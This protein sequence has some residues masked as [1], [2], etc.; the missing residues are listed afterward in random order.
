MNLEASCPK[1]FSITSGKGGTGKSFVAKNL[2]LAFAKLDKKV[3]A[4]DLDIGMRTLDLLFHL[5]DNIVFDLNDVMT[6]KCSIK[7]ALYHHEKYRNLSLLCG[8]A[9][10]EKDFS[11]SKMFDE[12][13]SLIKKGKY[14]IVI[15][16]LPS[17][18]GFNVLATQQLFAE[19][20]I[21]TNPTKACVRGDSILA[22]SL[23]E[24]NSQNGLYGLL[25]INKIDK[26][27]FSA[28]SKD[29]FANLDE[30]IDSIGLKLLGTLPNT[31]DA[32]FGKYFGAIAKRLLGNDVPL[33]LKV[34]K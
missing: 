14:D 20:I 7:D 27:A 18:I 4:I 17:G 32:H 9:F 21:V 23:R 16:D 2:A 5:E 8:P 6:E 25:I 15:V 22:N 30:I 3:L 13:N 19:P 1:I 11:A 31:Q 34:I 24:N 29:G 26:T 28:F 12:I 33:L 10:L